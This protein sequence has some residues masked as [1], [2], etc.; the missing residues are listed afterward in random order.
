MW[1]ESP[2]STVRCKPATAPA[3][4]SVDFRFPPPSGLV[5]AAPTTVWR[6]GPRAGGTERGGRAEL[7][8]ARGRTHHTAASRL[9]LSASTPSTASPWQG[10]PRDH[11]ERDTGVSL[12]ALS[13]VGRVLAATLDQLKERRGR[14]KRGVLQS[15]DP[16]NPH[17]GWPGMEWSMCVFC[18]HETL[19]QDSGLAAPTQALLETWA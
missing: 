5:A 18:A 17:L 13:P 16:G 4:F 3:C 11:Q 6:G 7:W 19:R 2:L 15:A 12:W 1:P 8:T 14:G 10:P 9:E